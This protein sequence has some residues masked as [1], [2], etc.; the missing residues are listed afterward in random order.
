MTLTAD[1]I[2]LRVNAELLD[3]AFAWGSTSRAHAVSASQNVL[4]DSIAVIM[5]RQRVQTI[6]AYRH[7]FA[8]SRTDTVR[9]KP[10]PTDSTD[11]IAGDSIIARFDTLPPKDTTKS[12]GM[13]Q[14]FAGG[15]ARSLYHIAPNDTTIRR[16]AVSYVTARRITVD[17]D[18]LAKV[19]TVTARDS[20]VGVYLDP[21]NEPTPAPGRPPA[22]RPGTPPPTA[23]LP[24][25]RP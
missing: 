10:E 5:P 7:A 15:G 14:L 20:V 3:R 6:R 1:T 2:D 13:K 16:A 12:P 25:R 21:T 24:P 9:F 17:F 8:E 4:A 22:P 18:T 11:W 19:S 23:S